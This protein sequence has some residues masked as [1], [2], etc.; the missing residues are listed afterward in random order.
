MQHQWAAH[1]LLTLALVLVLGLA[2]CGRDGERGRAEGTTVVL[3]GVKAG[4]QPTATASPTMGGAQGGLPDIIAVT[5]R[6]RPATVL[7]QNLV[8]D[9]G[10]GGQLPGRPDQGGPEEVPQGAGTGFIY[11]PAGYIITNNHVVAGAQRLRVQ[12][13]PPDGRFFDAQLV[14]ADPQTDL[15]VL[16]IDAPPGLPTVPLGNSG[17]LQVGE[18]VV[19]IGNAL[20]LPGGP[21]VTAGVV[22]ALGR[23][24]QEPGQGGSRGGPTLFGLIQTDA[25]INPGNSGGPLVNLRGEVVG[26][27][28]LGAA[29][30]N[31]IGFAIAIDTAK[32]IVEQLRQDGRV[33]RGYLGIVP[34]NVTPSVAAALGLARNDG[35]VVLQVG[36]NT[37]AARA[38]LQRGD[39]VVGIGDVP[40][41]DQEDLDRALTNRFRPGETVPVR[42]VRGGSEQTVQVTLGERPAP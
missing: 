29:G 3:A 40:V 37:P 41:Q 28:T 34:Q 4:A 35:L 18:W 38:G 42:L 20:A 26:V 5:N 8:D 24:I 10:Q 25:A 12:L 13:P 7:V 15:A 14:G 23:D 30:A 36:A 39:V 17:A 32:P 1:R 2:G 6:V 9:R 27:N 21:T 33:V 11:D 22:S 31:T 19:A 16:K